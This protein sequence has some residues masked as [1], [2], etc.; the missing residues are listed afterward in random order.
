M[1]EETYALPLAESNYYIVNLDFSF[2]KKMIYLSMQLKSKSKAN[3]L[4]R[5]VHTRD[6]YGD[7]R[8]D[9]F[10]EENQI[11]GCSHVR[12][13]LCHRNR[14]KIAPKIAVNTMRVNGP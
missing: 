8:C 7:F 11:A 13:F 4:L 2:S 5:P 10:G 1:L 14:R 12:I 6:I 3:R 9:F